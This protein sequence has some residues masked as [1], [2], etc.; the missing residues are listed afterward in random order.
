MRRFPALLG[1]FAASSLLG[2]TPAM[3]HSG[4]TI[5]PQA[6][7]GADFD[8]AHGGLLSV[9]ADMRAYFDG[10]A[11]PDLT[12]WEL[13]ASTPPIPPFESPSALDCCPQ[14]K[15]EASLAGV[16]QQG[17]SC[18]FIAATLKAARPSRASARLSRTSLAPAATL[19]ANF[20]SHF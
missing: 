12:P 7:F 15:H 6:L 18:T 19:N 20:G 3:A 17:A 2:L 9:F 8:V 5:G 11:N 1:L 13:I 16:S 4:V 14:V 10:L